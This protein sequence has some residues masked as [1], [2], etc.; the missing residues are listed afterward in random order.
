[1]FPVDVRLVGIA[2][3]RE[4]WEARAS[5]ET[6]KD[7]R[8]YR[9]RLRFDEPASFKP[10]PPRRTRKPAHHRSRPFDP[11]KT[12]NDAAP[13]TSKV[14]P[15]EVEAAQEKARSKHHRLLADLNDVLI[16]AGWTEIYEIPGAIDL[17]ARRPSDGRRVIFEAK[18]IEDNELHQLRSALAQLL[19][20]KYFYGEADDAL[21]LVT[22][23]P[24]SDRRSRFLE[25]CGVVAMWI[26]DHQM[27]A[28]GSRA[29]IT[30]K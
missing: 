26:S 1:M 10:S 17:S 5:D 16:E 24:I 7:R 19:E 27:R 9:F 18:T 12:P 30:L 14:T 15:E 28:G 8:V 6:G 20:Y 2:S 21:C 4:Y 23:G 13:P 22:D 11:T 3:C 29:T 25:D